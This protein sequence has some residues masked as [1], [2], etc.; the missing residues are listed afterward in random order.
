[1]NTNERLILNWG[2][3]FLIITKI[4]YELY[5]KFC[6]ADRIEDLIKIH[7]FLKKENIAFGHKDYFKMYLNNE[8]SEEDFF[9]GLY[10]Y[11]IPLSKSAVKPE[12]KMGMTTIPIDFVFGKEY[13]E[14]KSVNS[15]GEI[16]ERTYYGKSKKIDREVIS[17]VIRFTNGKVDKYEDRSDDSDFYLNYPRIGSE[18]GIGHMDSLFSLSRVLVAFSDAE[19]DYKSKDMDEFKDL[20]SN[21]YTNWYIQKDEGVRSIY[22]FKR[23]NSNGES[24]AFAYIRELDNYINQDVNK[25][26]ILHGANALKKIDRR[27]KE[28]VIKDCEEFLNAYDKALV[29]IR[30]VKLMTTH[31]LKENNISFNDKRGII[32]KIVSECQEN[33]HKNFETFNDIEYFENEVAIFREEYEAFKQRTNLGCSFLGSL[34]DKNKSDSSSAHK[35]AKPKTSFDQFPVFNSKDGSIVNYIKKVFLILNNNPMERLNKLVQTTDLEKNQSNKSNVTD[36]INSSQID[37]SSKLKELKQ[38]YDSEIISEQDY[39]TKKKEYLEKL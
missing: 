9:L 1:M 37:Y 26:I 39:E 30:K 7:D 10:I 12:I 18:E 27:F 2:N 23:W 19:S 4:G 5:E 33:L 15:K 20:V 34:G 21:V 22:N 28:T 38:L 17:Y 24:D 14:N 16:V 6:E 36:E 11:K 25:E 8:I 29:D 13:K 35:T 31:E 3:D 32:D